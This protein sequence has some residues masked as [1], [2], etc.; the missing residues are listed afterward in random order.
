[1]RICKGFAV[2]D[3]LITISLTEEILSS[4]C[5]STCNYVNKVNNSVVPLA[6]AFVS[7]EGSC[8]RRR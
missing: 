8:Q 1:M 3:I 5:H 2:P 4:M 7:V 6:A